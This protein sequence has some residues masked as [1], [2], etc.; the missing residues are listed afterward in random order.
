MRRIMAAPQ[1]KVI[2]VYTFGP[3]WGIPV[4]TSSP[5]GLKL[6]AWLELVG[7]PY[8]VRVENNPAKGPKGKC[9][10]IVVDGGE[11][12]GDSEL[13]IS[14]LKA[15][16]ARDLDA[17][18][19]SQERAVALALRRTFEEHYHQVW[20]HQLFI[21]AAS[22]PR[23]SEFFDQLPPGVRVIARTVMR[24]GLRRQLHARGVGRHSSTDIV[25]MGISDLEAAEAL[26][27]DKPFF[28]GDVPTEIDASVFGFLALTC[29]VP[30]P[31]PL[32]DYFKTRARLVSFCERMR[33]R[34]GKPSG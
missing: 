31:S 1:P 32:W 7:L 21:E 17:G 29:Y 19:G 25:R 2:E 16:G 15:A 23:A 13:V 18:L 12:F 26:L 10:W 14:R 27:G 9:P 20:E 11:P 24:R 3:A 5:F 33:E 30:C 4:P 8:T 6:I 34:I 28:F 22:W